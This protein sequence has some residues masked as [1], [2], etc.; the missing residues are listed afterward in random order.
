LSGV[1]RLDLPE[2]LKQRSLERQ[3]RRRTKHVR[4]GAS[5]PPKHDHP[6][7]AILERDVVRGGLTLNASGGVECWGLNS[8]GELGNGSNT[9]SPTP[10]PVTGLASGVAAISGG[11]AAVCARTA[12]GSL[13]CWGENGWGQ[14]GDGTRTS[15]QCNASGGYC[16]PVP[17]QVTGLTSGV[18]SFGIGPYSAC[19]VT[20]NNVAECWGA[21]TGGEF[22]INMVDNNGDF[23]L[24]PTPVLG[25]P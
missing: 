15:A 14:L 24:V 12:G 11:N 3:H 5:A 4:P 2:L 21:N 8:S 22:G 10:V 13:Q 1:E 17:V 7:S 20:S 19:A 18:T 16:S 9:N 6:R 25:F 23:F